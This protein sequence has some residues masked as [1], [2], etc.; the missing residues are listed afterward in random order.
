MKVGFFGVKS[1]EREI[2][3]KQLSSLESF[4]VGIFEG[5]V[6]DNLELAKNYDIISVFIYSKIDRAVLEKLP[7]LK[8]IATRSTGVDHIDCDLASLRCIEVKNVPEYGTHT[9]AEYTLG[10][11]LSVT[12]KIV[13]AHQAVENDEFTPVGLTGVDLRGLTLGVVGVGKIGAEV[14]KLGRA[15]GM[16]VMGVE[17]SKDLELAKRLKFEPVLLETCLKEA[18]VV[19]LHV[20]NIPQTHHLINKQNIKLMKPGSYLIN[21]CRGSVVETE[22]IIWALNKGILAGAGLDVVEEEGQIENISVVTSGKT[23]KEEIQKLLSYHMLRDR[24]DV[25]FT[26]HN[27]F[28]TKQ[29]IFRIVAATID[30]INSFLKKVG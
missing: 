12:K 22:A 17:K 24:D 2:L 4:G 28:N 11:M 9:V 16:R 1:W 27:A 3:E 21:T 13:V 8:M 10:L 30:N 23:S 6:Q 25:V 15:L 19:T 29:A 5:E 26:P 14:V 7:N 18:D 20:P